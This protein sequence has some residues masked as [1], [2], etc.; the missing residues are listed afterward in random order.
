MRGLVV[1]AVLVSSLA[2]AGENSR[3]VAVYSPLVPPVRCDPLAPPHAP[4]WGVEYVVRTRGGELL[5]VVQELGY[6]SART[7]LDHFAFFGRPERL[8]Q[9]KVERYAHKRNGET[10]IEI[11]VDGVVMRAWFPASCPGDRGGLSCAGALWRGGESLGA[12]EHVDVGGKWAE[13]AA[14]YVFWCSIVWV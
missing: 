5:V 1:L 7:R 2:C 3:P 13:V 11:E 8:L 14:T 4:L 12:L 10:E 9:R 6:V